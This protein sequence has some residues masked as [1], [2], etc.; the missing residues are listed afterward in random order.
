[1]QGLSVWN[2]NLI[3]KESCNGSNA[4]KKIHQQTLGIQAEN[5]V[6]LKAICL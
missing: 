2:P 1:M 5:Y 6:H 3:A 4:F